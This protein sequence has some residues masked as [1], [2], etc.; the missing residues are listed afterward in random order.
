M[1]KISFVNR[2]IAQGNVAVHFITG[3]DENG[4]DAYYY[5]LA[6]HEKIKMLTEHTEEVADISD[7]GKIIASGFGHSPSE[8][9]KKQLKEQY[10]YD[11]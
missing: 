3:K 7:Y 8:S 9:T 6:S 5:V 2:L 1:S 10:N 11:V 4:R